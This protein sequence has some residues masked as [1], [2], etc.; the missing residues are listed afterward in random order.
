MGRTWRRAA[1][2]LLSGARR[3]DQSVFVSMDVQPRPIVLPVVP[4][5]NIINNIK[6]RKMR[7]ADRSSAEQRH[8]AP[9]PLV[10]RLQRR[11]LVARGSQVV[12]GGSQ[13]PMRS[14]HVVA[15]MRIGGL[16]STR[17]RCAPCRRRLRGGVYRRRRRSVIV[18]VGR[19]GGG[20]GQRGALPARFKTVSRRCKRIRRIARSRCEA[21]RRQRRSG[22]ARQRLALCWRDE[23]RWL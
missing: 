3:R 21:R 22:R 2:I 9:Q 19:Q 23:V 12:A 20:C 7:V 1:C 13:V 18:G 5:H 8:R 17:S 16:V 6:L 10:L 14:S 4:S 11:H 15:L